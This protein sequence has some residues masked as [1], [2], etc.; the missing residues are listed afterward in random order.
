MISSGTFLAPAAFDLAFYARVDIVPPVEAV[1]EH[2]ET[3]VA[4]GWHHFVRS[5]RVFPFT[6]HYHVE[7]ELTLITRGSGQ[8]F[9]GDS[10]ERYGPGDLTL[11]GSELPHTYVS[12][13]PPEQEAVVVQF[14]RDFLGPQFFDTPEFAAIG[15]L[16]ERAA[17]GLAFDSEPISTRLRELSEQPWPQR[18]LELLHILLALS[19]EP[20]RTLT[21][22]GYNRPVD[23]ASRAR[24]DAVSRYL[25]ESYTR[26]IRLA[27]VAAVAHLTP[28]AFSRFF[29]R[30]MGRTLTAYITGLR[31]AEAR[32]LLADTDL[33]VAEVAT[34]CGYDNLSNFN[35]RF[36][37]LEG[38]TP[39]DYRAGLAFGREG[40]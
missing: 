14:G 35:R 18:T 26:P 10:I 16:L 22:G 29:R 12:A 17:A 5:E 11:I 31:I 27:D 2:I 25:A 4:A 24:I 20:A 39:R 15:R 40:A 28:A 34:R 21:S 30:V 36:R 8:R 7:F 9:V 13:A 19:G 23:H 33:P 6:W 38:T 1:F 32:R 3:S 37:R